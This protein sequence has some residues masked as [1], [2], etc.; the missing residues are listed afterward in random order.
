M[1]IR[2]IGMAIHSLVLSYG[3]SALGGMTDG[4]IVS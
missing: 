2:F 1:G 4:G 3:K